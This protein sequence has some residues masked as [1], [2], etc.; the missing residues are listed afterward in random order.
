MYAYYADLMLD[1]DLPYRDFGFEYPPLAAPLLALGG[2]AGTGEREYELAF[3]ALMFL[4]ACAVVLLIGC[5]R[6]PHRR[7][8]PDGADRRR[9]RGAALRRADPHPLRPGAGGAHARRA[10]AA[11]RRASARRVRRAGPGRAHEGLPPGGGPGGA[12]LA[13]WRAGSAGRRLQGAAVAG[14]HAAADRGRRG[15][16]L[17]GRLRGLPALPPRPPRPGGVL[18][19]GGAHGARGGRGRGR[20]ATEQELRV[21][22]R[23]ASGR[24]AGARRCSPGC[25]PG[26]SRCW[27]AR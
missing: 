20:A 9:G 8:S 22:R 15:G 2:V 3:A 17:A 4:I 5:A 24:A 7:G 26:W 12:R 14:G 19:G 23:A 21:R 18:A 10:P 11:V 1:G 13:A 16:A 27:P 25:S 6:R